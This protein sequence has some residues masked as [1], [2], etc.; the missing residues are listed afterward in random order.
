MPARKDAETPTIPRIGQSLMRRHYVFLIVVGLAALL[1]LV[2]MIA[3]FPPSGTRIV[4][5]I[6]RQHSIHIHL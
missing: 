1:R 3:Y 4:S 5:A 6:S 2:T